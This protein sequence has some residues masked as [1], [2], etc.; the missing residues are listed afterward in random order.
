MFRKS[1]GIFFDIVIVAAVFLASLLHYGD[2]YRSNEG[3]FSFYQKYF[4]SAV[5]IYCLGDPNARD[6]NS[7]HQWTDERI[8]LNAIS[9][10]DI[11]RSPKSIASYYNGWH[12]THPIFSTLVGYSWRAFG[13]KW[14]ALWPLA[15]SIAALTVVSFYVILRCF[16]M[17]WYLALL[18]F[19][20]IAPFN[21]IESSFLLL[22]DFSKVP[23]ILL[24]FASLGPLFQPNISYRQRIA[25]LGLSSGI[26]VVGMGFRQD[27]IV[28]VPTILAAAAL[29]SSPGTKGGAARL[30]GDL[31]VVCVSFIAVTLAVSLL[32]T[33]QVLQL[34]GYP[35]FLLEGFSDSFW[36]ATKIKFPGLSFMA[37]YS[38]S[39]TWS[40]VHANATVNVN[41][42]ASFDPNY[43]IS[44]FDLIYKFAG[45]SAA[46][47]ITRVFQA[48][49]YISHAYWM[50]DAPGLWAILLLAPIAVGQWRLGVFLTFTVLSLAAAGSMQFSPR[51]VQH[52]MM[53]DRALFTIIVYALVLRIWRD[54]ARPRSADLRLAGASAL[55]AI[56]FTAS[57]VSAAHFYQ[58]RKLEQ[59]QADY[60]AATWV[61]DWDQFAR[62]YSQSAELNYSGP[63]EAILRVTVDPARCVGMHMRIEFDIDGQKSIRALS[64]LDGKPRDLYFGFFNKKIMP[65][66]VSLLPEECI[67]AEAWTPLHTGALTPIQFFDPTVELQDETLGRH[68][69]N[70]LSAIP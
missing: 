38:D 55:A 70:L 41:Y 59:L 11:R 4:F 58:H 53:L 49:S 22:R 2:F 62:Q 3:K 9:C 1:P 43:S 19:P 15:G 50:I 34:Q 32:K 56:I 24:S 18:L 7:G 26:A 69:S 12:D 40:L 25:A 67:V 23:F 42:F 65:I 45:L 33:Q 37:A 52:L 51:H 28:I 16:G 21:L 46:D 61:S 63:A 27:C 30:A 39:L 36:A 6:D 60:Q 57:L 20:A 48:L 14:T 64:A 68:F 8:D 17:P 10:D 29:T 66:K 54:T 47:M 44:G 31:A 13:F 5:D 35:H